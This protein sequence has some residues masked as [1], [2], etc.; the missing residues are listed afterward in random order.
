MINFLSNQ[1]K[2]YRLITISVSHYCE[3]ARW[4]LTKLQIPFVEEAHMPPFHRLATGRVGG[5]STPVLVTDAGAFTDSTDILKYIDSIAP[6]NAK[7]YPTDPEQRGQVEELED[8]FDSQLGPA[9]R[10]W[11]Y[12]Y[13]VND[14]NFM[15]SRWCQGVPSVERALFPVIFPLMRKVVRQSYN[16]TPESAANAYEQIKSI[17]EKVS[18]LLADGRTYLVGDNFSAADLTFAA[19]AAPA[20]QPQE[21]LLKR[22]RLQEFPL[23]MA[24]EISAFRETPAGAFV[25]RLHG[26]RES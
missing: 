2:T 4:A 5:K 12:F 16:I 15:K 14:Y 7:L 6:A 20:V 1:E 3:K 25:L 18:E 10:C 8:L 13:V 11:G 17:F 23:Q 9:T 21:H 26:N 19:L 24:S 22:S